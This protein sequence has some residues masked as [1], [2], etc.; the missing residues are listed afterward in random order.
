ME[1]P[2]GG[3]WTLERDEFG[4]PSVVRH[5]HAEG[6]VSGYIRTDPDGQQYARCQ[7]C[8]AME[9]IESIEARSSDERR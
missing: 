4:R 9:S 6:M 5:R 8:S 7:E 3:Y 1:S 2:H